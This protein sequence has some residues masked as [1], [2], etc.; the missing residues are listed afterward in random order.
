[1]S[2]PKASRVKN[3]TN[4]TKKKKKEF[5]CKKIVTSN[6]SASSIKLQNI[7]VAILTKRKKYQKYMFARKYDKYKKVPYKL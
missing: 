4:Y 7:Y 3:S 5:V 2:L 6:P 1:M